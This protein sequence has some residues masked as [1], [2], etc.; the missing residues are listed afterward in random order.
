MGFDEG[1]LASPTFALEIVQL[2]SRGIAAGL[3]E[4]NMQQRVQ[5]EALNFGHPIIYCKFR[6]VNSEQVVSSV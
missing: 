5:G 1:R 4:G 2:S 3:G 6:A